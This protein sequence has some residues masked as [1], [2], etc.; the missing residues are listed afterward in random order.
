L[1]NGRSI[2]IFKDNW[3]PSNHEFKL[4][5]VGGSLSEAA[6]MDELIFRDANQWTKYVA[7]QII[8]IPLLMIHSEDK[9]I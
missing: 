6:T 4:H 8:K 3:I 7:H 5:H 1:G 2:K 9:I